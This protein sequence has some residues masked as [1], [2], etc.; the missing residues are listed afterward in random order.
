MSCLLS[1]EHTVPAMVSVCPN[2]IPPNM[3][4]AATAHVKIFTF[5]LPLNY[6]RQPDCKLLLLLFRYG[7]VPCRDAVSDFLNHPFGVDFGVGA[8]V[9]VVTPSFLCASGDLH[10]TVTVEPTFS[11]PSTLVLPSASLMIH[12]SGPHCNVIC[13]SLNEHKIPVTL[14]VCPNATPPNMHPTMT[15]HVKIFTFMLPLNCQR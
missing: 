11:V 15:T 1:H 6:Q 2:A 14:I 3:H 8:G 7:A 12:V 5:M 9:H 10:L 4:P 13:L